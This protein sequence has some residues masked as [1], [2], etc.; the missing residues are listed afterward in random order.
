MNCNTLYRNIMRSFSAA[1]VLTRAVAAVSC[2]DDKPA[3]PP[4]L[5]DKTYT[6]PATLA[7]TYD[8][9]EMAGKSVKLT[10][11]S[12][13]N[14][15][16]TLFSEFD[17]STL[18]M[19]R[20]TGVVP[21][22][23]ILPGSPRLNLPVKLV[24]G[25]GC[26]TFSGD[27]S[28][29]F[30]TFSYS[31]RIDSDGKMH[32][33]VDKGKLA[34]LDLA[35]SV[36]TPTPLKQKPGTI[37]Y[38]STPFHLLWEVDPLPDIRIPLQEILKLAVETPCIPVYNGTAYSSISQLLCETVKTVAFMPDGNIPVTYISTVGGSARLATTSGP[39]LQYVVAAPGVMKLYVNPLSALGLLLTSTSRP[40]S[41]ESVA[42]W[43][44]SVAGHAP[45]A[46]TIPKD[47]IVK[48][49]LS[50]IAPMIADG[51]PM[52]YAKTDKTLDIYVNTEIAAAL[53]Q[54]MVT[55]MLKDPTVAAALKAEL[56]KYPELE[57]YLPDIMKVLSNLDSYLLKTTKL[58]VGLSFV[59]FTQTGK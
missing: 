35:G 41:P 39:A 50:T 45:E 21:A 15:E 16:L 47:E 54:K 8:G 10:P 27:G 2:S 1:A 11:T 30:V 36:W 37:A 46:P 22:P 49:L 40:A 5:S 32:F 43:P 29:P 58:E 28:T 25:D 38:E 7:V 53:I 52:A 51:L 55:P 34:N 26:Y 4:A 23:G 59:T 33:A 44:G 9:E 18:S 12:D 14:A 13:G 20:V 57:P 48:A 31:G 24:A 6:S 3:A 42:P 19:E 56:M 17:L